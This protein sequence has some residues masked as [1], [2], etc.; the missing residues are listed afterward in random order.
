MIESGVSLL[1]TR[2]TVESGSTSVLVI[3]Y[4][5]LAFGIDRS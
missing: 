2:G 3:L 4:K 5:V 1:K